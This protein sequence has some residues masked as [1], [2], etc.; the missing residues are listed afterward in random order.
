MSLL[1]LLSLV[2]ASLS[3]PALAQD[4]D[5]RAGT[6]YFY[7]TSYSLPR[8]MNFGTPKISIYCDGR[9]I[10]KL[11]KES[12]FGVRV[13]AGRH[14]F[15]SKGLR[16]GL[17]ETQIELD[18]A[19]G[20]ITYVRLE[21]GVGNIKWW[22]HLRVVGRDE[23]ALMVSKLSPVPADLIED[24]SRVIVSRPTASADAARAPVEPPL[25]NA[26]IVALKR[27]GLDEEIVLLKI[28]LSRAVFDLSPTGEHALRQEGVSG[29]VI[30]AMAQA[31]RRMPQ[32]R[33]W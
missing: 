16:T 15:A 33:Q 27:E 11:K 14:S 3:L 18:V 8:G 13:P 23:G 4:H 7:F 17:D 19:P 20:R 2:I 22:A 1:L 32:R 10:A 30:A 24:R 31:L 28:Q 26:D 5:E 21:V 25:T 12:F 9:L 29:A 6:L